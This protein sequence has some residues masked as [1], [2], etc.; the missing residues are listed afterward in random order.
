MQIR[1]KDS[2]LTFVIR[3]T[4]VLKKACATSTSEDEE[5]EEVCGK[6]CVY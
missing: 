3:E 2:V 6:H 1:E 5:E 4:D